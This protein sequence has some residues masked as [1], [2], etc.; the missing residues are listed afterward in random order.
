MTIVVTIRILES[1]SLAKFV[2][3]LHGRRIE[4]SLKTSAN[5]PDYGRVEKAGWKT[6]WKSSWWMAPR[7]WIRGSYSV[8][9][10]MN[11]LIDLKV[12]LPSPF[13]LLLFQA[14]RNLSP[15]LNSSDSISRAIASTLFSRPQSPLT[16]HFP[17]S[18]CH[19][20]ISRQ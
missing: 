10:R 8:A 15:G 6:E 5:K 2:P 1:R 12:I 18:N 3:S 7:P 14:K 11:R 20:E 19:V 13:F 4:W 9:S 17:P 16:P